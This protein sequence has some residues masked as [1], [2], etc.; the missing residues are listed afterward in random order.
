MVNY[1]I[2]NLDEHKKL[3][4]TK[5]HFQEAFLRVICMKTLQLVTNAEVR[6]EVPRL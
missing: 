3:N 4:K 1:L 6:K 2:N 5:L